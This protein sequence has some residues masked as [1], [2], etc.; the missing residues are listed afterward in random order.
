MDRAT[1][2]PEV[3]NVEEE[4]YPIL[5]SL[6]NA[7]PK[8]KPTA[9]PKPSAGP[10]PSA[11]PKIEPTNELPKLDLKLNVPKFAKIGIVEFQYHD[12]GIRNQIKCFTIA[13]ATH[14]ATFSFS[15]N[16]MSDIRNC[17]QAM[18]VRELHV[19]NK[20]MCRRLES[21]LDIPVKLT[22]RLFKNI[23]CKD[24]YKIGCSIFKVKNRLYE[25]FGIKYNISCKK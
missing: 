3:F 1:Q 21:L 4:N 13:N 9:E 11:K 2:I 23:K 6:L 19:V 10:E 12:N 25:W 18:D 7:E 8:I 22:F 16:W 14:H 5:R 15:D 20:K 24:C 17:V